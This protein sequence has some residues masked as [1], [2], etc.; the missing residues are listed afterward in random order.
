MNAY[1]LEGRRTR[2]KVVPK[3]IKK[4]K[5]GVIGIMKDAPKYEPEKWL[6]PNVLASH[7]C[8][9]YFLNVLNPRGMAGK[10][11]P[12][13]I[14]TGYV[15][16]IDCPAIRKAV[17]DDNPR[18][19]ITWGL[20]KVNDKCP[21]TYFK[22]FMAVN[23]NGADYHFYRQDRDGSWSHKPGSTPPSKVDA[24][25][26]RI[27]NP[28]TASRDYSFQGGVNYD[29]PCS[30]FCVKSNPRLLKLTGDFENPGANM[31][32]KNKPKY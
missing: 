26:K 11:Q 2:R 3:K 29:V 4:V 22:G 31:P 25:G 23:S 15:D 28:A 6:V 21:K 19:I 8:Y 16:H 7:N 13:L 14:S 18:A 17:M 5:K 20:E 12:G 9:S 27:F 10:P 24:R 1:R 32:W 30:F